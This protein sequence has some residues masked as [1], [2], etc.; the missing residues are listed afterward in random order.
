M[1][2][3]D[4]FIHT[5]LFEHTDRGLKLETGYWCAAVRTWYQ[6][7]LLKIK[8]VPKN[9][10]DGKS[11]HAF[12]VTPGMDRT[13][14]DALTALGLD[15]PMILIPVN[16]WLAPE[17]K[18]KI[19]GE[20]NT[21]TT[22]FTSSGNIEKRYRQQTSLPKRV[23]N[24]VDSLEDWKMIRQNH[25]QPSMEERTPENWTEIM[26]VLIDS[27]NVI[28]LNAPG[29]YFALRELLGLEHA[30]FAFIDAPEL[31]HE[32]MDHLGDFYVYMIDKLAV[33]IQIDGLLLCEDM[34]YKNGPL[35]SPRMFEDFLLPNYLKVSACVKRHNIP[36][37]SIDTD[38]DA[39]LLIPYFIKGGINLIGPCEVNAGMDVNNIR[40]DFPNLGLYGGVNKMKLMK[41]HSEIDAE[42]ARIQPVIDS[43]GYI[44]FVDHIV[45]PGIP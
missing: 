10:P 44:P 42:L 13:D 19:I 43:G 45:P 24:V 1:K 26:S 16:L 6:E 38:G 2:A 33:L 15:E 39:R 14:H 18:E 40:R 22:I 5:V 8:G 37:F 32:I 28:L 7:G 23:K 17:F 11:M 29:F 9:A 3:K 30:L 36:V 41:D 25:L 34:C 4:C 12:S 20:D 31:V 35:I 27:I 21:Y